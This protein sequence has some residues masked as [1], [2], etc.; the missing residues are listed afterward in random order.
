MNK[1]TDKP[2]VNGFR[3]FKA[4]HPDL[5]EFILFNLLSN[6]ATITNFIMLWLGTGWLFKSLSDI[7]FS[8]FIFHYAP[9]NGGLG[10]FFSFL[11]AYILAQIVNFFCAT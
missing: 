7:P 3:R 6:V 9:E 10:G 8:W 5:T 1:I 2:E 4:E 11:F